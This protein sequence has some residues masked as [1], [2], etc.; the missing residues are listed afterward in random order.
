AYILNSVH[1]SDWDH[2]RAGDLMYVDVNGDGEISKG[3]IT[4]ENHG[5]IRPIGNAMPQF[6]FGF[7]I[8]ANWKSFDVMVAGYG[9]ARQGWYPSGELLW[10]T[11]ERP[12]WSFIRKDLMENVWSPENPTGK[13]PQIYRGY[14]ALSRNR[15]L[16]AINDYYLMNIGY[17]RIKNLTVGYTLPTEL[18]EKINIKN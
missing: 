2:L 11:S 15:S 1:N 12:Y 8:N 7:T 14:G 13:F 17:L 6:A 4:L 3:D 5:D 10:A 18:T 9:V 16:G